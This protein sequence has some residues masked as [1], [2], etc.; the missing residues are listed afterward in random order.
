VASLGYQVFLAEVRLARGAGPTN[1]PSHLSIHERR[2]DGQR[3][4]KAPLFLVIFWSLLVKE[5]R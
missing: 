2:F 1:E 3:F 5:M 4:E